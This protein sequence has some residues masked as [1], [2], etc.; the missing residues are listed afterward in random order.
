MKNIFNSF[1]KV[2][3]LIFVFTFSLQFNHAFSQKEVKSL[4]PEKFE[5]AA[6]NSKKG[7]I[8]DIRTPEEVA[9]G[10][11]EGAEFADFLNDDFEKKIGTLDKDKAYYIYCRSA[12]RTIPATEKMIAL[13]FKKVYMLEGGLNNWIKSGKHVVK[14]D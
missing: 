12:N 8:L 6:K 3:L 14:T 10:H 5:K 1:S 7:I 4:T 2:I 11:I 9:D 13:G